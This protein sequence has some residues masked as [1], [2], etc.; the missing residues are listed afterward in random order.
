MSNREPSRSILWSIAEMHLPRGWKIV[1]H[2]SDRDGL[3]KD[4]EIGWI[5]GVVEE[6]DKEIHCAKIVDR[7]TLGTFLHECGHVRMGHFRKGMHLLR[8]EEEFE[9]EMYAMKGLRDAG[10]SV[11]RKYTTIAR[12]YVFECMDKTLGGS[13]YS[14]ELLKFVYGRDWREHR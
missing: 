13:A 5:R 7:E 2:E 6:D 4:E 14:D 3:W 9:A 12:G 10:L 11:P 1:E 8:A